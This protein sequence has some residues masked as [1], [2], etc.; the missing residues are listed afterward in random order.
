MTRRPRPNSDHRVQL[1]ALLIAAV[2]VA[3]A[4]LGTWL[5]FDLG[6]VAPVVGACAGLLPGALLALR[7]R[8]EV[9]L[10]V[11][12]ELD[13]AEGALDEIAQAPSV[14]GRSLH[15][16]VQRVYRRHA[17]RAERDSARARAVADRDRD[18]LEDALARERAAREEAERARFETAALLASREAQLAYLGATLRPAVSATSGAIEVVLDSDLAQPQLRLLTVARTSLATLG[19]ALDVHEAQLDGDEAGGGEVHGFSPRRLVAGALR[20]LSPEAERRGIELV[21]R[22]SAEVPSRCEADARLLEQ[23]LTLL[24][25]W[26]LGASRV[27][28]LIIGL[29]VTPLEVGA[30]DPN[31]RLLELTV[32]RPHPVQSRPDGVDLTAPITLTGPDRAD[33]GP[34][35]AARLVAAGGGSLRFER[36]PHGASR[37]VVTFPVVR[38]KRVTATTLYGRGAI[39][40]KTVLVVDD[41]DA[42]RDALSEQLATWRLLPT[43]VDGAASALQALRD[44]RRG[45][46]PFDIIVL[47]RH[48]P[49]RDGLALLRE[50]AADTDLGPQRV[51]LLDHLFDLARPLPDGL[52]SSVTARVLKPILPSELLEVLTA[53]LA[54]PRAAP[55]VNTRPG[56][57]PEP[58]KRGVK[59]LVA[60]DNPVNQ[61]FTARL[62]E[63]RGHHVT[64]ASNGADVID[65]LDTSPE[66]F[67]I[68]LMDIQMPVLDGIEATAIIRE[69]ERRS[70]GPR[71][72]IVAVTAHAMHGEEQRMLDAGLDAY[73]PKPIAE[74]RLFEAIERLLPPGFHR[75]RR[76]TPPQGM[77]A[78]DEPG[79]VFDEAK[80]MAF[81]AGDHEFLT[82][83]VELFVETA[84]KQLATIREAVGRADA[85]ALERA[86]HQL[87]GSVSN[88]A[89]DRARRW[90]HQLEQA[91]RGGDLSDA[92]AAVVALEAEIAALGAALGDLAKRHS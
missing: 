36:A 28:H 46:Q 49:G 16:L 76:R 84:P 62:L 80:V 45:Q 52:G 13:A 17:M 14:G 33:A 5:A 50:I 29:G 53:A 54:P 81:V 91:G 47:D 18:T 90:A 37:A 56:L 34:R 66:P 12:D 23:A 44:A 35:V 11:R 69:R 3:G 78:V 64:V 2:S 1:H 41:L 39:T 88:F 22:C 9:F 4:A 43:A 32:E 20:G 92:P 58:D 79:A 71:L 63:K 21:L 77:P 67:D 83:L 74:A 40:D 8:R 51:I 15:E 82:T 30:A 60:E 6:G 68:I 27:E 75:A 26:S 48:M 31:R 73:I 87:K 65:A 89:A 38:Q 19:A 55:H 59:V 24:V 61:M 85:L 57:R 42:S 7:T 10:A 25:V 70:G 86:A 72:P